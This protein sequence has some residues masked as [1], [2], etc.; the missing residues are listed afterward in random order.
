MTGSLPVLVGREPAAR[1]VGVRR[2]AELLDRVLFC[3]LVFFTCFTILRP[4]PYDFV[5]ILFIL[6]WLVLGIR[7][8]RAVLMIVGLLLAYIVGAAVSVLPYLDEWLSV[9]WTYQFV[10]LVATGVFFVAFFSDNTLAR[11]SLGLRAYLASCL[12]AAVCGILNY[13]GAFSELFFTMEGRAAG[14]F[15]DPNSLG[16][17]LILSMLYLVHNFLTGRTRNIVA[18]GVMLLIV[19]AC[20]FLSFSRGSWGAAVVSLGLICVMTWQASP[21]REFRRRL[22]AFSA[23]TVLVATILVGGLLSIEGVAERFTERAQVTQDYDE[24]ETGRFGN[25]L[26]GIPMLVERPLGLG[27]L[28]WRRTFALEPHNSY[29][30]AFAN[31]GWLGGFAFIGIVLATTFV[32]FRL[33][34]T[35]SPYQRYA[36]IVWPALFVFFLQAF[37]IDIEKWRHVYLMLGMLWGLEAA[38]CAWLRNVSAPTGTAPAFDGTSPQPA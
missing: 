35:P 24:G 9:Q 8:H 23:L 11:V 30:G 10:Y 22:A 6:L 29:L 1:P 19:L 16:S 18:S 4:S 3:V 7:V 31:G 32:G 28:R 26:R 2:V 15:D 17:F 14:V 5:A 12:F 21:T 34:L 13:F 36:Q 33:C 38:R 20:I 25:Q 37:Q 27:P